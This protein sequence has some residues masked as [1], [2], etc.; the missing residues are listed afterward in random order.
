MFRL[1]QLYEIQVCVCVLDG[2]VFRFEVPLKIHCFFNLF[3]KRVFT[4]FVFWLNLLYI[5]EERVVCRTNVRFTNCI[6]MSKFTVKG[7]LHLFYSAHLVV[8]PDVKFYK[9][10]FIYIKLK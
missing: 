7:R 8:F 5:I 10:K 9:E 4:N 1:H 2:S 6:F 3:L